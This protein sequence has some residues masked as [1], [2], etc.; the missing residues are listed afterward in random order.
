MPTQPNLK[1]T[2]ISDRGKPYTARTLDGRL[3]FDAAAIF[4]IWMGR[5]AQRRKTAR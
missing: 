1:A 5:K 3:F 2:A 4:P